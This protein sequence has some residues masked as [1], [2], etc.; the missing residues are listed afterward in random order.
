MEDTDL[1]LF[2]QAGLNLGWSCFPGR[3][4]NAGTEDETQK[5]CLLL[6]KT[7]LREQGCSG[8]CNWFETTRKVSVHLFI[9]SFLHFF[10]E[11][12]SPFAVVC[13]AECSHRNQGKSSEFIMILGRAAWPTSMVV[14]WGEIIPNRGFPN[15]NCGSKKQALKTGN[16]LRE[17]YRFL[18]ATFKLGGDDLI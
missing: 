16:S 10:N 8:Y 7:F 12:W 9:F 1:I 17:S 14:L 2:R 13:S 5:P 11:L 3:Q 4:A 6:R 18:S 15:T